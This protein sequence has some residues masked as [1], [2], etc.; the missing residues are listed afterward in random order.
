MDLR[1]S[2]DNIEFRK[3][4][5]DFL[6]RSLLSAKKRG[7]IIK[8]WFSTE[9]GQ[10]IYVDG[11]GN[12][13]FGANAYAAYQS[14]EKGNSSKNAVDEIRSKYKA[15]DAAMIK[16]LDNKSDTMI[17]KMSQLERDAVKAYTDL[18]Y[19][20]INEALMNDKPG[21]TRIEYD[22][23]GRT[24]SLNRVMF[25]IDSAIRNYRIDED[26]ISYRAV[27]ADFAITAKVGEEFSGKM[28]YSTSLDKE[29]VESFHGT[30][31]GD[32]ILEIL[33]PKGSAA[34]YVGNASGSGNENE[35]LISRAAKYRVLE[36]SK[37][38]VTLEVIK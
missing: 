38:K 3:A 27:P 22:D 24:T 11:D 33:I 30:N 36:S 21:N 4:Q 29:Y 26:I 34:M 13:S 9:D 6:R 10:H 18:G 35:V 16:A 28:Y 23:D 15:A 20:D 17:D 8:G 25:G 32:Q 12:A 14:D 5:E 2:R 1:T 19:M 7:I 37:E 31:S